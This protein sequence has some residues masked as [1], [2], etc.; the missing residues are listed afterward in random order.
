[1]LFRNILIMIA[2]VK[3]PSFQI[4][5]MT[6]QF[7]SLLLRAFEQFT[8]NMSK[9]P[10]ILG[11]KPFYL[12]LKELDSFKLSLQFRSKFYTVIHRYIL[13][14]PPSVA[15]SPFTQ[16]RSWTVSSIFFYKLHRS[17]HV[18]CKIGTL[19]SSRVLLLTLK[20]HRKW[21]VISQCVY[22][23]SLMYLQMLPYY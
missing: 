18:A 9:F 4:L 1:M 8:S 10:I 21:A 15:W 22:L 2:I 23:H 6:I 12:P 7:S 11:L 14:T 19:S 13:F 17:E 16:P 5:L 3:T 20:I